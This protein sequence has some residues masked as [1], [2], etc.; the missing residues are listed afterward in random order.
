[1]AET[2][3]LPDPVL[4]ALR[5][6]GD[7]RIAVE[8]SVVLPEGLLV[9]LTDGEQARRFALLMRLLLPAAAHALI[10]VTDRRVLLRV[11]PGLVRVDGVC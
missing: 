9:T 1:M 2:L 5:E 4:R 11:P 6:L 3:G 10:E 7:E 8:A